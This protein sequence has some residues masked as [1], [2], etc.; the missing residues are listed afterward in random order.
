MLSQSLFTIF[1]LYIGNGSVNQA[2]LLKALWNCW[3]WVPILVSLISGCHH[4][5]LSD[6][7][8]ICHHWECS[9]SLSFSHCLVITLQQGSKFTS[10]LM[11]GQEPLGWDLTSNMPDVKHSAKLY[12]PQWA[13]DV[14]SSWTAWKSCIRHVRNQSFVGCTVFAE[15]LLHCPML[16]IYCLWDGQDG[17]F[18]SNASTA[19]PDHSFWT[20]L[21]ACTPTDS[22]TIFSKVHL[23]EMKSRLTSTLSVIQL[24]HVVHAHHV[25]RL[26]GFTHFETNFF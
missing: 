10:R 2:V 13:L 9:D 6:L 19:W 21:S 1:K 22:L 26:G 11:E 25:P 23:G 3:V 12:A 15:D 5:S 8:W 24:P 18:Y 14:E 20:S 16:G 4:A 17:Q 7:L